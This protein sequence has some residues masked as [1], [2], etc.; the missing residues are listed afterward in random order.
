MKKIYCLLLVVFII[1]LDANEVISILK[2]VQNN[3]TLHM[4]HLQ[5]PFI[6]RPFGVE[7]I[8]QFLIRKDISTSCRQSLESFIEANPEEQYFALHVLKIEQQ[9]SAEKFQDSCLLHLSSGHSYSEALLEHGYARIVPDLQYKNAELKYRFNRAFEGAKRSKNGI[10]SNAE[11]S[12]C[13]L[14]R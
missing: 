6:C 2:G 5:Q 13:F 4:K 7:T 9:Y 3:H 1:N 11:V 10:W 8:R 14:L 12:K